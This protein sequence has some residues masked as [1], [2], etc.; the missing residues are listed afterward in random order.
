MITDV[1]TANHTTP[2]TRF[3]RSIELGVSGLGLVG[4]L[5]AGWFG[6]GLRPQRL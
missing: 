3:G 5:I 2:A 1:P 4:L 6:R